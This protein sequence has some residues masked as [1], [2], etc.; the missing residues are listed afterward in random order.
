MS[1][2]AQKIEIQVQCVRCL[3]QI[4]WAWLITYKSYRYTQLVYV[5]SECGSVIKVSKA[6]R[7]KNSLELRP[8][9]DNLTRDAS[10]AWVRPCHHGNAT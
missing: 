9:N 6:A 3:R 7:D 1:S 5:C 2:H 8:V 10:R 4:T